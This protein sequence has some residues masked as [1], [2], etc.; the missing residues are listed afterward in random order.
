MKIFVWLLFFSENFHHK[1]I[2]ILFI[3]F[4]YAFSNVFFISSFVSTYFKEFVNGF[5]TNTLLYIR[6][7]SRQSFYCNSYNIFLLK[8]FIKFGIIFIKRHKTDIHPIIPIFGINLIK[9]VM[10]LPLHI[11][12]LL[13]INHYSKQKSFL[14]FFSHKY[15]TSLNTILQCT[16]A[17][18]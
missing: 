15:N 5:T 16:D 4:F 2:D 1:L 14:I 10:E 17:S 9:R 12:F 8:A 11:F 13:R 6:S 3:H 18:S 7:I